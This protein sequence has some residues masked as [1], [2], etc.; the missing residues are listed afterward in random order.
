MNAVQNSPGRPRNEALIAERKTQI[1]SEAILFFAET[2]YP[3]ADMQKLA[4]RLGIGK[5]TLYRY[6]PTKEAL[7]LASVDAGMQALKHSIA[8]QLST[9]TD[10]VERIRCGFCAYLKYFDQHPELIELLIIERAEFR[11]RDKTTYYQYLEH[12]A[13][14]DFKI[15]EASIEKGI[16]RPLAPKAIRNLL[17]DTLYGTVFTNY[18]AKRR[19]SFEEQADQMLDILFYGLL[20]HPD[21]K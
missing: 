10:P 4:N 1:V 20:N 19:A 6:F 17:S 15:I 16:I 11:D 13:E 7:F 2:G 21:S 5:G 8:Q 14:Q 12:D 18:Y 3:Q 9:V